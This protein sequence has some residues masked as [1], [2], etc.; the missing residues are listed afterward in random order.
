[1]CTS[2]RQG[3]VNTPEKNVQRGGGG[4]TSRR[5]SAS[6]SNTPPARSGS[7]GTTEPAAYSP[8]P[9]TLRGS[10]FAARQPAT[11]FRSGTETI[12]PQ[13]GQ[14]ALPGVDSTLALISSWQVGHSSRTDANVASSPATSISG[15]D[16][17]EAGFG[18][19]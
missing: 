13:K 3:N 11:V 12:A 18:R 4:A 17:R 10:I 19:D 7:V 15:R 16:R 9:S 6:L 5:I 2:S 8:M 1:M 14:G